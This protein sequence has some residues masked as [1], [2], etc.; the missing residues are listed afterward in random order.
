MYSA[1]GTSET[2]KDFVLG[3]LGSFFFQTSASFFCAVVKRNIVRILRRK[4]E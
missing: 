2:P 3:R 4:I 1:T